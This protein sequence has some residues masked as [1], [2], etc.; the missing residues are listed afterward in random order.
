[1][2]IIVRSLMSFTS[3]ELARSMPEIA[4]DAFC[5]LLGILSIVGSSVATLS[6]NRF[7][8]NPS[9]AL[10]C[11]LRVQGPVGRQNPSQNLQ[12]V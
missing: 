7:R 8:H 9:A 5:S 6:V 4:S 10:L 12:C 1:M 2:L 3:V 11:T